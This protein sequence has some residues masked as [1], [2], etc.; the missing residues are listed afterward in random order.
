M[1]NLSSLAYVG[2][3][4]APNYLSRGYLSCLTLRLHVK[5]CFR[6]QSRILPRRSLKPATA[7]SAQS[8]LHGSL[9][10]TSRYLSRH[11]KFF[12]FSAVYQK[13]NCRS[14][15]NPGFPWHRKNL[16]PSSAHLQQFRLKMQKFESAPVVE[17]NVWFEL[18]YLNNL[19]GHQPTKFC[20]LNTSHF[21]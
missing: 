9:N 19:T 2:L 10:R 18:S 21:S 4:M 16:S 11:F 13:M 3:L 8:P 12:W 1:I 6:D 5:T 20:I 17:W 7:R 14:I 15:Q